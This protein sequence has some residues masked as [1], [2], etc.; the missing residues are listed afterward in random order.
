MHSV[1]IYDLKR[2]LARWVRAGGAGEHIVITR[3]SRPIAMLGPLAAEHVH[4]G[5]FTKK[6][7]LLPALRAASRGRYLA[8]LAEDREESRK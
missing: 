1:P 2:N 6:R 4:V 8:A 5:A 7:S 3:H